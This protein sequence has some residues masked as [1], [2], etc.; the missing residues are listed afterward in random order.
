MAPIDHESVA[1][2]AG[3]PTTADPIVHVSASGIRPSFPIER[4]DA[5]VFDMDGVV[6]RTAVVHFR[7]WKALFDAYLEGRAD[8]PLAMTRP[9]DS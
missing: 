9:F 6:T 5:V 4:L 1:P 3:S 7:A 8:L 2:A